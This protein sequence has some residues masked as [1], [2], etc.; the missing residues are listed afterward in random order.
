MNSLPEILSNEK[1][2]LPI[3]GYTVMFQF[4]SSPSGSIIYPSKKKPVVMLDVSY[5]VLLKSP[6]Y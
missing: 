4:T 6:P 3:F 1:Y 2:S 5:R